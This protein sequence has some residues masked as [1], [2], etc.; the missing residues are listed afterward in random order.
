[1]CRAHTSFAAAKATKQARFMATTPRELMAASSST[2]WHW[3]RKK[4]ERRR[5]R[6]PQER[7]RVPG[8]DTASDT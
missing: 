4:E 1:L 8:K 7:G 2:G 6:P 3:G 5:D